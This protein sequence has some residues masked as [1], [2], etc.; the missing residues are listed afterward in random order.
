MDA[1]I[2]KKISFVFS[3]FLRGFWALKSEIPPM[4]P[5]KM[6]YEEKC[7]KVICSNDEIMKI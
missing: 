6:K 5:C 4:W 3:A 2:S 1:A 7:E